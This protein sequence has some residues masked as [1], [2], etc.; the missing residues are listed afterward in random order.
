MINA[1]AYEPRGAREEEVDFEEGGKEVMDGGRVKARGINYSQPGG[2]AGGS[3]RERLPTNVYGRHG[4]TTGPGTDGR[5]WL[6][7]PDDG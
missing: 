4:Y 2:L 5:T 7:D 3:G 6:A 1:S